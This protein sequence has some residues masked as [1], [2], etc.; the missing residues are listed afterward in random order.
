MERVLADAIEQ[1][2]RE[3]RSSFYTN[4]PFPSFEAESAIRA[5]QPLDLALDVAVKKWIWRNYPA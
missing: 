3:P 4:Q 5:E 2:N 1:A